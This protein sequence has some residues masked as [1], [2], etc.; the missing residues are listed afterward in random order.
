MRGTE[1]RA[2]VPAKEE[3]AD[4]LLVVAQTQA[5]YN[6]LGAA[7][8]VTLSGRYRSRGGDVPHA[9][10]PEVRAGDAE[11]GGRFALE[12]SAKRGAGRQAPELVGDRRAGREGD[13]IRGA[14]R[15]E[16]LSGRE[17]DRAIIVH[18]RVQRREAVVP[19]VTAVIA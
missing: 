14:L 12:L 9:F 8:F 16:D 3:V 7:V 13:S 4:V 10:D 6:G 5:R 18:R 15:G 1:Q 19:H 11:A 2:A 17:R